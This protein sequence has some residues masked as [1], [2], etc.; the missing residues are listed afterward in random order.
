MLSDDAAPPLSDLVRQ[1]LV[2][3]VVESELGLVETGEA[4]EH[5]AQDRHR[6]AGILLLGQVT[7]SLETE[8]L[9]QRR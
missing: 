2:G 8:T 5:V 7:K 3:G 9:D 1:L 6:E 4:P